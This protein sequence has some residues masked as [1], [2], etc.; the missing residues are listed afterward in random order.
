MQQEI[1]LG[2]SR[3][4]PIPKNSEKKFI[5][6]TPISNNLQLQ[7]A[8]KAQNQGLANIEDTGSEDEEDDD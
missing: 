8:I 3:L 1:Q 4:K 7:M 5:K 6:V 2:T